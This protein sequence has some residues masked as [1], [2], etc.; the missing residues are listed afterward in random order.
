M[1]A[2]VDVRVQL[3]R[4]EQ[5]LRV[6]RDLLSTTGHVTQRDLLCCGLCES[7]GG[8]G[9]ACHC[10]AWPCGPPMTCQWCGPGVSADVLVSPARAPA[11]GVYC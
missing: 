4:R 2:G 7:F 9:Q 8:A 3:V 5:V 11:A 6:S 1:W 10:I